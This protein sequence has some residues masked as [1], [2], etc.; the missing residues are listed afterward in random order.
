MVMSE[1]VDG[2]EHFEDQFARA[3]V[4]GSEGWLQGF[5]IT[6]MEINGE[7]DLQWS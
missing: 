4:T 2:S 1:A 3:W 5:A 7:K 6:D